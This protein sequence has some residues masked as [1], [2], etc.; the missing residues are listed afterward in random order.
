MY[1]CMY[2]CMYACMYVCMPACM[3]VCMG[4]CTYVCMHVFV[5]HAR[6]PMDGY[7][8]LSTGAAWLQLV[9]FIF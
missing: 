4:M 7:L 1:V 5:C 6:G 2:V 3:Y 8:M 9:A